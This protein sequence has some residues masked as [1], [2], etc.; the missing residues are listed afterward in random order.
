MLKRWIQSV[1]TYCSFLRDDIFYILK[2]LRFAPSRD[3]N[4]L[5]IV[6]PFL[7][8]GLLYMPIYDE[9]VLCTTLTNIN[10][11]IE[12]LRYVSFRECDWA[13]RKDGVP[14]EIWQYSYLREKHPD[15]E[16]RFRE[17]DNLQYEA[18]K[19]QEEY[20][21]KPYSAVTYMVLSAAVFTLWVKIT[22]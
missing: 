19:A 22:F 1:L 17:I 18:R 21:Q 13:H 9:G 11:E 5:S 3:I 20:D 2:N 16:W 10:R 7:V 12:D 8:I 14:N 4:P 15:F 6:L